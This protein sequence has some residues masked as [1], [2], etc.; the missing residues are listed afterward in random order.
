[1]IWGYKMLSIKSLDS[2]ASASNY[3]KSSDYYCKGDD[4]LEVNNWNGKGAE[5][6]GLSGEVDKEKFKELL[7]GKI[8]DLQLGQKTKDGLKHRPGWDLTFSAPK[9]VSLVGLIGGDQRLVDA[10]KKASETTISYIEK[11]YAYSRKTENG[12]SIYTNEK[13]LVC[14]SFQQTT[15]R[16]LDPQLHV[17]NVI[18]NM[19]ERADGNWRSLESKFIFED[20]MLLG[21]MFR[22][23]LAKLVVELGYEIEVDAKTGFFEIK[24]VPKE[25]IKHFSKRREQIEKESSERGLSGG[26]A[27]ERI[28]LITRKF[29]QLLSKDQII[30]LWDSDAKDKNFEPKDLIEN[31]LNKVK[32]N[33]VVSDKGYLSAEHTVDVCTKSLFEME[34]VCEKSQILEESLK[35]SLGECTEADINKE[36]D[37]SIKDKKIFVSHVPG[38]NGMKGELVTT[39]EGFRQE[40]YILNL[41][42]HGQGQSKPITDEKHLRA[43]IAMHEEKSKRDF[44]KGQVDSIRHIATSKDQVV[45][46]QGYAGTGKSYMLKAVRD[47]I[48]DKGHKIRALGEYNSTAQ[49]LQHELGINAQTLTSF[50]YQ[51]EKELADNPNYSARGEVWILDEASQVNANNM[52]DLLTLVRKTKS[53]LVLLGDK[54]QIGAV[55]WGKPFNL[56]LKNGMRYSEMKDIIRQEDE[57]LKNAVYAA[58]NHKYDKSL[59]LIKNDAVIGKTTDEL[60]GLL[61]S[62][63]FN[64]EKSDRDSTLVVVP[65]NN[66][67]EKIMFDIRQE[68][69][70][71]G[72]VGQTRFETYINQRCGLNRAKKSDAR[73]YQK[74]HVVEF[75][76]NYKSLNVAHKEKLKVLETRP[77]EGLVVLGRLKSDNVTVD[78]SKDKVYWN[79]KKVAGGA[80]YGVEVYE[81][82]KRELSLGDKIIW[83]NTNKK[84][85]LKNGDRGEIVDTVRNSIFVKFDNGTSK[86]L[87]TDQHKNFDYVYAVTAHIAQGLT[88]SKV[89]AMCESWRKNLVNQKSFYVAISR[90]KH[91]AK[92]YTDDIGNLIKGLS[93][94]AG[95][96]TS[97]I[98]F[99]KVVK[100]QNIL[101]EK[102]IEFSKKSK[103]FAKTEVTARFKKFIA[104]RNTPRKSEKS[105]GKDTNFA[106]TSD[107]YSHKPRIDAR[108]VSYLLSNNAEN[109]AQEILGNYKKKIGKNL[110]FGQN[111]GSLA[112]V[113]SGE[114]AGT[115]TDFATN[116]KGNLITLIQKEFNVDFKEA[117]DIAAKMVNYIPG[118][119]N[120]DSSRMTKPKSE[121][122]EKEFTQEQK[123]KIKFANKLAS[124]GK[125]IKDTLA[126]KY[127]KEHRGLNMDKWPG[128]LRYHDGVKVK[129]NKGNN[130]AL[131]VIARDKEDKIQSVQAI[132]LDKE[133]G[134]KADVDI[135]KQTFGPVKGAVF[136]ANLDGATSKSAIV[137][138]GPEDALSILKST[139]GSKVFASFGKGNLNNLDQTK[140]NNFEKIT[141]ALDNDG[142]KPSEMPEILNV[143]SRMND[144][145]K[146]VI[147]SQPS[148]TKE[149]YNDILKSKGSGAVSSVLSDGKS[150]DTDKKDIRIEKSHDKS[151]EKEI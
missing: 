67:R 33:K 38:Y 113:I 130:P 117:L 6:L 46:V 85:G 57:K 13:N 135:Q 89:L 41:M 49:N 58:I 100:Q 81:Q 121:A 129:T 132:Y 24:G 21:Q 111:K 84:E 37:K 52:A 11:N 72:E 98:E 141:I 101:K 30:N 109:I 105:Q 127:L 103:D 108:E 69:I 28:N 56:M 5:K 25:V 107:N 139:S 45:G 43:V 88:Y 22:S 7:D 94:R 23:N 75:G 138:E 16:E 77:K 76:N 128:D 151:L 66:T 93:K 112:V 97:S 31:S 131:L 55:E 10:V 150:F 2:S 35:M 39:K 147:L 27:L 106:L 51:T 143:A 79:P 53:K 125:D 73:F 140:V 36:L 12:K 114:H 14:A 68:L 17:H 4:L 99:S 90:A 102:L 42:K 92:V 26:K 1:M 122:K 149:D 40:K 9:S 87:N 91:V 48:Q 8:G 86:W 115:W 104:K 80:K 116:E 120:L 18:L 50:I 134:K 133:T 124:E 136:S 54:A 59:D 144:S 71:R 20:K 19:L 118:E 62:D 3:Y 15:S 64:Q 34:A 44:K 65:D 123:S 95:E 126:E 70:K 78:Q 146:E 63:Y 148:K 82:V 110:Y 142:K 61:V 96:K 83:T 29:K 47:I 137:C 32:N 145:G 119:L 60:R 74:D